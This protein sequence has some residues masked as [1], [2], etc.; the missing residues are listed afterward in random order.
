LKG[1]VTHVGGMC[2]QSLGV[3][4]TGWAVP[5]GSG[6]LQLGHVTQD[7]VMKAAA[8]NLDWLEGCVLHLLCILALDRFA[9]YVSDQVWSCFPPISSAHCEQP[10][11]EQV[12]CLACRGSGCM[13]T[14]VFFLLQLQKISGIRRGMMGLRMHI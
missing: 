2:A 10:C 8:N 7:D 6:P 14:Q 11:F 4:C 9:D 5:G 3:A 1:P 12:L 13:D